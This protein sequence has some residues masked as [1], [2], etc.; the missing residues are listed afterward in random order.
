MTILFVTYCTKSTEPEADSGKFV[1]DK[2]ELSVN[3][4]YE[5]STLFYETDFTFIYHKYAFN[6]KGSQLKVAII[7]FSRKDRIK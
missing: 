7:S 2:Q 6:H 4:Y 5:D 3:K 1:V